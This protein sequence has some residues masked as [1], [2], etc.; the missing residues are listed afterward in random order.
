MPQITGRDWGNYPYSQYNIFKGRQELSQPR[1]VWR[2]LNDDFN[3]D[4][5]V[6]QRTNGHRGFYV[7]HPDWLSESV[8]T[9]R[10]EGRNRNPWPWEVQGAKG[11][12]EPRYDMPKTAWGDSLTYPEATAST[13]YWQNMP[14]DPTRSH[15]SSVSRY[16]PRT[17]RGVIEETLTP[18]PGNWHA[19]S[20]LHKPIDQPRGTHRTFPETI[21]TGR[22]DNKFS[23]SW[24]PGYY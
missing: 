14:R 10:F 7:V 5:C 19:P 16:N 6:F 3:H 22:M 23:P 9:P 4:G 17:Q 15:G 18:L 12:H 8:N 24:Y 20:R 1:T 11:Y 2:E 13:K 21:V